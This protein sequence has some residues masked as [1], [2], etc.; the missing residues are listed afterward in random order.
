MNPEFNITDI[1]GNVNTRLRK[2]EAGYCDVILMA[3]VGLQ[4]IGL[5]RYISEIIDPEVIIPAVSQGAIAVEMRK[6]DTHI[7][8]MLR[9]ISHPQTVQITNAERLFLSKLE[10]GCQIPI[11]CYSSINDDKLRMMGFMAYVDGTSTIEHSVEGK[12]EEAEQLANNLANCFIE[13][14]SADILE[15]IRK[16]NSQ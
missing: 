1:R 13:K 9:E 12:L 14:G 3:A 7:R 11:G 2:M 8:E 10:G 15:R 4:R 16:L 6:S 5:D